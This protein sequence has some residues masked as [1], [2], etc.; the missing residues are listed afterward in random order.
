MELNAKEVYKILRKK[1]VTDLYHANTV[2]T[3]CTFLREGRLLARGTLAEKGLSQT[4]QDSDSKDVKYGLWYDLFLDDDDI[5]ER[6][7]VGRVNSYGPVLFVL[8]LQL[9]QKDWLASMWATKSNPLYWDKVLPA[10]RYFSTLEE[11]SKDYRKGTTEHMLVLR[12]IGGVL[13]LRPYLKRIIL[14]D[15]HMAWADGVDVYSAAHGALHAAARAGGLSDLAI[16][17]R[18]CAE[19]CVCKTEYPALEDDKFYRFFAP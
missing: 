4:A 18:P 14:D 10:K 17:R 11:F 3:S 12:H 8:D 7:K 9:L 16:E 15:P 2:V 1:K 13:R 5:H 19:T 6:V